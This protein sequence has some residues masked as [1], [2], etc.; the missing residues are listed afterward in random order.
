MVWEGQKQRG[1]GRNAETRRGL[2]TQCANFREG[3]AA[4][5]SLVKKVKVQKA[6]T[7]PLMRLRGAVVHW[8]LVA[9]SEKSARGRTL[10]GPHVTESARQSGNLRYTVV[11]QAFKWQQ[12]GQQRGN[13]R[14][15]LLGGRAG[16][17]AQ[18]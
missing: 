7:D 15:T 11:R 5:F 13:R 17:C 1:K 18:K 2:D 10:V 6:G 4:E 8:V 12:N 14:A 3:K 16:F 9:G